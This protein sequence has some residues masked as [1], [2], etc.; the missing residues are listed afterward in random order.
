VTRGR[1]LRGPRGSGFLYCSQALLEAGIS[2]PMID[3]ALINAQ[4]SPLP[5]YHAV[6]FELQ[7]TID[8]KR[9]FKLG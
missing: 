9:E 3:R 1:Y 4:F 5:L 8:P 7:L 6:Y 2:P